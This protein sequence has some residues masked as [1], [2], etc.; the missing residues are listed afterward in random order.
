MTK[1]PGALKVLQDVDP[2]AKRRPD[3][4]H[5]P[6]SEPVSDLDTLIEALAQHVCAQESTGKG[7]AGTVGVDDLVVGELGHGVRLGVRVRG[8]EVAFARVGRGRGGGDE[9]G[10]GALGDD[11]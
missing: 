10:F 6:L 11:D 1:K 4:S 9:G 2:L 7:I 3:V 5:T 8:G